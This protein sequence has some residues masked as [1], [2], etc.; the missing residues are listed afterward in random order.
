MPQLPDACAITLGA[1]LNSLHCMAISVP[2][3]QPVVVLAS[4]II[5]GIQVR[6]NLSNIFRQ[7]FLNLVLA[8][9]RE[10]EGLR[11]PRKGRVQHGRGDRTGP[12]PFRR[13]AT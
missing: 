5:C 2:Y 1:I 9:Q 3:I 7:Y 12:Y 6:K 13:A 11:A 8:T 4:A 10:Q